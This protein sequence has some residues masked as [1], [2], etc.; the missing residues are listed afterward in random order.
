MEAIECKTKEEW[1]EARKGLLTASDA[2]AVLGLSPWKSPTA[3]YAEKV[4][5][6]DDSTDNES[7]AWGRALQNG[8]GRRFA[9]KTG[10]EVREADEYTI[11]VHEDF[12]FIGAT[13][14][15]WETDGEKGEGVLETKATAHEWVGEPPVYYQVQL[16]QQLAVTGRTW[17][18]LCAFNSLRKPPLWQ[19]IEA[20]EKFITR[21]L[22]K[23]EEF[24]WR[25][26][27]RQPP[28]VTPEDSTE[29]TREALMAL[30]PKDEGQTVLLP[31]EAMEWAAELGTLKDSQKELERQIRARESAIK[32]AMGEASI[33]LLADGSGFSW[34]EVVRNDPPREAREIRYRTLRR[35]KGE[36]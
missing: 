20:N 26:T 13:L 36:R 8:I 21:L 3:L 18:T 1:L 7:M 29:S 16:Q 23:L 35:I 28:E 27:N 34:K 9:E 2:A 5:A 14:D 10:R 30:Y 25:V 12:P 24:Q 15:F 19:D 4:G 6:Y 17:G 32:A 31:G 11:Y 22:G 33:G